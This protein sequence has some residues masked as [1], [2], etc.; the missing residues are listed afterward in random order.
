[1]ASLDEAATKPGPQGWGEEFQRIE[2]KFL[3]E[4]RSLDTAMSKNPELFQRREARD[5]NDANFALITELLKANGIEEGFWFSAIE[6]VVFGDFLAWLAQIIGSC[7]ASGGMRA[8]ARRMLVEVFLLNDPEQL[9]GTKLVGPLNVAHF[10]PYSYRAGRKRAGINS[11]DGSYCS[12]HIEG[13]MEDGMLPCSTPGLVADAYPEPQSSRL[14]RQ[15]GNSNSLMNQFL[16]EARRFLLKE[17]EKVTSHS[18]SK[19]LIREHYK[20]HMVCSGWAF[21]PDYVHPEWRIE[22]EPVWIYTRDRRNSWA[23]NM[24]IDGDVTIFTG[25]EFTFVDNSWGQRAHK[26]GSWFVIKA[27]EH[28]TWCRDSQQMSIGDID[29]VDNPPPI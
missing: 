19:Q 5:V 1:M 27:D 14:Y 13:M 12:V 15:W 3:Q 29:M 8:T 16:D 26:N 2:D 28:D 18:Q 21:K 24:T 17:S 22:G 25:E 23:H 10:A 4:Q 6:K 11:G 9:F 7:V 20:P